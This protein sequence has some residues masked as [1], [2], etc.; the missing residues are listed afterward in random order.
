MDDYG[1]PIVDAAYGFAT[2]EAIPT[3]CIKGVVVNDL[4]SMDHHLSSIIDSMFKSQDLSDKKQFVPIYDP[5][6][7]LLWPKKIQYAELKQLISKKKE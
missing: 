6:G 1:H 3:D 2:S 5:D 4:E 7:N